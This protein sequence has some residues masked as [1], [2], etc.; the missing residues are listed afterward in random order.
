MT[1]DVSA[2]A[3]PPVAFIIFNRPDYTRRVFAEI[4][5]ARPAHL[6]IIADG[7][8][9]PA[10]TAIC[11]ETRAVVADVDWPCEVHRNYAEKNLGLK[12]R[13]LSGLN[14][15]FAQVT[16]GI[17]LE[18]DQLPHPSFFRFTA[19]MLEK[20]Q[21]DERV[22]MVTGDN[23]LPD[24]K[25]DDSYFFSKFPPIWGWATW[26]RAWATYDSDMAGW[27]N[28]E[29]RKKIKAMYSQ[30]FM[31]THTVK[32][33]DAVYKKKNTWDPQWLYACLI[34]DGLCITPSVNLVSNIGIE[35]THGGGHNQNLPTYDLYEMGALRHPKTIAE[36]TAYD[37]T[38]YEK[39]FKGPDYPF[40]ERLR[41]R[42]VDT[43]VHYEPLK[44]IYRFLRNTYRLMVQ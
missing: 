29:N 34:H 39:S 40:Q 24:F 17:I 36:N 42:V 27:K 33:F 2:F 31:A 21:Y 1:D 25:I 18:D 5:K 10:E 23:F 9:T 12:E 14:W 26:R 7:P 4:R 13:F 37:N 19:E 22:M 11:E 8:R 43:L 3:V 15:F 35:G 16:E 41:G 6:F 28:R 20:Y 30:E 32:T 38:F 44:K